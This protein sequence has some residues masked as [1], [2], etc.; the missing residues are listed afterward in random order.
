MKDSK[1]VQ[2]VKIEKGHPNNKYIDN[3]IF[4]IKYNLYELALVRRR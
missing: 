2:P 1:V 4:S 3:N